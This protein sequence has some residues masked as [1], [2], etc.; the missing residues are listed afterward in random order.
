[1][2]SDGTVDYDAYNNAHKVTMKMSDAMRDAYAAAQGHDI[3]QFGSIEEHFDSLTSQVRDSKQYNPKAKSIGGFE[4]YLNN[5]GY[6]LYQVKESE[7]TDKRPAGSYELIREG[8]VPD[9]NHVGQFLQNGPADAKAWQDDDFKQSIEDRK[10]AW[11]AI[12]AKAELTGIAGSYFQRASALAVSPDRQV[13]DR[14]DATIAAHPDAFKDLKPELMANYRAIGS[15]EKVATSMTHPV[16]QSVMQLKHN[17][18]EE[19]RQKRDTIQNVSMLTSISS[20][21]ARVQSRRMHLLLTT[22]RVGIRSRARRILQCLAKSGS[23]PLMLTIRVK[24][25]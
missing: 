6:A 7:A 25:V 9:P 1:M 16:T 17:T 19:I 13:M 12:N 14:V 4:T 24:P 5:M 8:A 3:N 20:G 21:M 11:E 22:S 15:Y 10:A 23:R 2:K 18:S